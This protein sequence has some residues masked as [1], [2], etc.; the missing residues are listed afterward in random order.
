MQA[1]PVRD[2]AFTAL[3]QQVEAA[4]LISQKETKITKI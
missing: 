2:V 4:K 1:L 3:N